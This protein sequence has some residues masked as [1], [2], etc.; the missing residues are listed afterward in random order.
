MSI[1]NLQQVFKQVPWK[2][3]KQ[4][5]GALRRSLFGLHVGSVIVS[6]NSGTSKSKSIQIIYHH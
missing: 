3:F 6:K 1:V 4:G 2:V 5:F